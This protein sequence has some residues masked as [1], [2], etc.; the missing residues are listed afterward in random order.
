MERREP[1]DMDGKPEGAREGGRTYQPPTAI[2]V[3]YQRHVLR[4]YRFVLS[5]GAPS[6]HSIGTDVCGLLSFARVSRGFARQLRNLLSPAN[7]Y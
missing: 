2:D 4:L 1:S 6:V 3:N 5:G 7:P